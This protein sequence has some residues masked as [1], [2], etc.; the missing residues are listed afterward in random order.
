MP[1]FSPDLVIDADNAVAG[2]LASSVAKELL[3]GR[4]VLV[5]NADAAVVSGNPKWVKDQFLQ[6]IHRGDPYHGPFYPKQ[7]ERILRR[8]VWGMLPRKPR[9]KAALARLRVQCGPAG[10]AL[11]I[12]AA[13]NTLETKT[14]T[15]AAISQHIGGRGARLTAPVAGKEGKK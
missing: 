11:K 3:K 7:P 4:K 10:T 5:V 12:R 9:G 14:T 2:R 1:R 8:I 13:E 6:K 15:L